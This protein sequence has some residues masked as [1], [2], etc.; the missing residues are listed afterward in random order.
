[1]A[2]ETKKKESD[3]APKASAHDLRTLLLIL[4][5]TVLVFGIFLYRSNKPDDYAESVSQVRDGASAAYSKA[6]ETLPKAYR[7]LGGFFDY[8][9]DYGK[10]PDLP[11]PISTYVP[12]GE[13]SVVAPS[14]SGSTGSGTDLPAPLSVSGERTSDPLS[15]SG[16]NDGGKVGK[17]GK[18]EP[19]TIEFGGYLFELEGPIP[20]G[21]NVSVSVGTAKLTVKSAKPVQISDK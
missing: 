1:M 4:L 14:G 12:K 18:T 10:T 9:F 15:A 20:E 17:P 2:E 3:E 7:G 13:V 21:E 6:E 11:L 19:V 8:V 16:S 5:L